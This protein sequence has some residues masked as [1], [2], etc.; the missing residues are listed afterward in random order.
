[1]LTCIPLL[2]FNSAA[3]GFWNTGCWTRSNS[4][5]RLTVMSIINSKV[6]LTTPSSSPAIVS[7][8]VF[9]VNHFIKESYIKIKYLI[10]VFIWLK[11]QKYPLSYHQRTAAFLR[12]WDF[13][14]SSTFQL[15]C[16]VLWCNIK[17]LWLRFV[18]QPCCYKMLNIWTLNLTHKIVAQVC[19][20]AVSRLTSLW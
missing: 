6:R 1:M 14:S 7:F 15:V 17:V 5:S 19:I 3:I 13:T 12:L 9:A 18:L 8:F 20:H 16:S 4:G 10:N 2:Y 11:I